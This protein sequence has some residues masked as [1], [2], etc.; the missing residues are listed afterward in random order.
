MRPVAAIAGLMSAFLA[1][2]AFAEGVEK[3]MPQLA[4]NNPLTTSQVVWLALIFFALYLLL[5]KWALPQVA[6]VLEMRAGKIAGD[7]DAARAA[8]AQ[9]DA[10]VAELTEATRSAHAAAQ[11]E[12]MGAIATAKAEAGSQSERLNAQLDAQLAAAE[13][14]I[15]AARGAAMGAIRQVAEETAAVVVDRLTGTAA[16]PAVV[17]Q[18]VGGVLAARGLA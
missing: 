8:K 13:A 2:A 6:G 18:A 7:L 11:A 12:I 14:R 10:A 16:D 4:F 3:G 17:A 5:S 1:S 9:A 15:N